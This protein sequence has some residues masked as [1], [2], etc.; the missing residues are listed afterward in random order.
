MDKENKLISTISIGREGNSAALRLEMYKIENEKFKK[1]KDKYD[2]DLQSLISESNN[3]AS[4]NNVTDNLV[5][6]STEL[7]SMVVDQNINEYL[8]KLISD[9]Y[10]LEY[11]KERIEESIGG[12]TEEQSNRIDYHNN[13]IN[14]VIDTISKRMNHEKD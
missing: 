13:A 8:M 5:T 2:N 14:K 3:A 12:L 7:L 4:E 11:D 9:L 10:S 6:V 1:V